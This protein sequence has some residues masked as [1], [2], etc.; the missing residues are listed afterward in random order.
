VGRG[1]T[2][3]GKAG[4]GEEGR[5][6]LLGDEELGVTWRT[7]KN[8]ET[9]KM[10]RVSGRGTLPHPALPVIPRKTLMKLEKLAKFYYC[11]KETWV[12]R[13]ARGQREMSLHF[14]S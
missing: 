8:R 7:L 9:L 4:P 11:E 1:G 12:G 10:I 6:R 14:P 2:G 3:A 5:G 13:G